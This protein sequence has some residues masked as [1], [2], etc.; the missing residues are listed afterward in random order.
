LLDIRY[1][2]HAPLLDA[3]RKLNLHK[4]SLVASI[5]GLRLQRYPRA[6]SPFYN[7]PFR[8]DCFFGDP[9]FNDPFC[10]APPFHRDRYH[11]YDRDD[12]DR[13]RKFP[14]PLPPIPGAR[15]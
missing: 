7:D 8:R 4:Y 3:A 10:D 14:L 15:F 2:P 5:D 1:Q 6:Y 13:G 12:H 11:D 9:Y